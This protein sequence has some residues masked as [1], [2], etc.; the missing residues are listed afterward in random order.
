MTLVDKTKAILLTYLHPTLAYD[1]NQPLASI[2]YYL[3][4]ARFFGQYE[5]LSDEV[6]PIQQTNNKH[7]MHVKA[8]GAISMKFAKSLVQQL[9]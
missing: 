9:T 8:T 4:R 1:T 7:L 6:G 3:S 2:L 5:P